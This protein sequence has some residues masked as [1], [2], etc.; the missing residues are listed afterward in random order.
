MAYSTGSY[1]R[2]GQSRLRSVVS[3]AGAL[4]A[5]T[6]LVGA[7]SAGSGGARPSDAGLHQATAFA[8]CMR[9]QG[10][11][12]F[13]NPTKTAKGI[14]LSIPGQITGTPQYNSAYRT[15]GKSTGYGQGA[16]AD[17]R[18]LLA[19]AKNFAACMR[20]HGIPSFPNPTVDSSGYVVVAQPDIKQGPKYDAAHH[21]CQ[22]LIPAP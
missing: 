22:S 17:T 12:G 20:S 11:A 2:S 21:A 1:G 9:S 13:P 14:E 18:A 19:K 8:A 16:A 6:M 15:C 4:A 10:I 5:V 3:L 7:C